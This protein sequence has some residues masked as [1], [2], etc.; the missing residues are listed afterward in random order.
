MS[1]QTSISPY[2]VVDPIHYDLNLIRAIQTALGSSPKWKRGNNITTDFH[3]VSREPSTTLNH[4]AFYRKDIKW[5]PNKLK[6]ENK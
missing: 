3:C 1:K 2:K 6:V 4:N 5:I